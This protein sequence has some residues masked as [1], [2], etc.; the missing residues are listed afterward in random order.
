MRDVRLLR[1]FCDGKIPVSTAN[2]AEQLTILIGKSKKQLGISDANT[3]E[4]NTEK[5]SPIKTK[6]EIKSNIEE[7]G[8]ITSKNEASC[9][10]AGKIVNLRKGKSIRNKKRLKNEAENVQ[11]PVPVPKTKQGKLIYLTI[12]LRA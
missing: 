3:I 10:T 5:E 12:R 8:S 2:D 6:P 1:T 9:Q 11:A 7:S 4:L